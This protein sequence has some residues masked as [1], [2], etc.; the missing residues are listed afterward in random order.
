MRHVAS[1]GGAA[2]RDDARHHELPP[3]GRHGVDR[4]RC[5][6]A[7]AHTELGAHPAPHEHP[8]APPTARCDARRAGLW[9]VH[10]PD[11]CVYVLEVT[12]SVARD[13][14]RHLRIQNEPSCGACSCGIVH[15]LQCQAE[16]DFAQVVFAAMFIMTKIINEKW[17]DS[18]NR[19][20][21]SMFG[22]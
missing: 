12:S 22:E 18:K 1:H 19:R 17:P 2:L 14:P 21:T 9:C 5:G 15:R 7:P 3:R 10:R 8:R 20:Q 13:L 4:H 6:H 16:T 11:A